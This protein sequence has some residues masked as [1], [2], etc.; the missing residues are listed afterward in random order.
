MTE[1]FYWFEDQ[2][3]TTW[4]VDDILPRNYE[5]SI[6]WDTIKVAFKRQYVPESAISMIRR[7]WHA[8]K[9]SRQ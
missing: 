1:M 5:Y 8:L 4:K 6:T 7:E 2:M 3:R 9:F